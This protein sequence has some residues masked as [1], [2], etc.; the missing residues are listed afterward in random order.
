MR[1]QVTETT[2][3]SQSINASIHVKSGS[4]FSCQSI[5]IHCSRPLGGLGHLLELQRLIEEAAGFVWEEE[6]KRKET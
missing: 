2:F 6:E 4:N 5:I 1:K 3:T